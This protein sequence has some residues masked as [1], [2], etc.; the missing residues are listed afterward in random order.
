M[1][2]ASLDIV[3][4][5]IADNTSPLKDYYE[6]ISDIR[7]LHY[8]LDKDQIEAVRS[9][10]GVDGIPYYILV[11]RQGVMT[12]RRDLRDHEKFRSAL[13]EEVAKR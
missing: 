2:Y 7:G 9:Q 11:D 5:Y 8:R 6:I 10:F 12:G 1:E 4:I 3:W 13:L